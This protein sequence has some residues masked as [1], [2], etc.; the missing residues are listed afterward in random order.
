M[1]FKSTYYEDPVMDN[2]VKSTVKEYSE[3]YWKEFNWKRIKIHIIEQRSAMNYFT[4]KETENYA[5]AYSN[6]DHIFFFSDES[7][8]KE[9][10]G[11][12]KPYSNIQKEKMIRHEIAHNYFRQYRNGNGKPIFLNEWCSIYLSKQI[13]DKP[14]PQQFSKFLE[15]MEEWWEWVYKESGFVVDLLIKEF[16]KETFLDLLTQ[17]KNIYNN[18]DFFDTFEKIYWQKL[19]YDFMNSLLQKHYIWWN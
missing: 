11:Y 14:L 10:N 6:G 13:S 8:E 7:V 9:T 19:T 12:H 4:W 5:I 17:T 3:F 2:F 16:S 15:Y 1:P 18:K